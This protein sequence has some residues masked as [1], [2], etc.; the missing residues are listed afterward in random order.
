V[1][2]MQGILLHMGIRALLGII[3]HG[4]RVLMS[5]VKEFL[6]IE[7]MTLVEFS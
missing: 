3:I 7:Y 5:E 4:I 1:F 2:H 6:K